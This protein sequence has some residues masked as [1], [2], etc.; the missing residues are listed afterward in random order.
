MGG[1]QPVP[2]VSFVSRSST[3]LYKLYILL[4][5]FFD[6]A[7]SILLKNNLSAILKKEPFFSEDY[8]LGISPPFNLPIDSR[9]TLAAHHYTHL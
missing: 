7:G 3:L 8:F 4:T 2:T 6:L 1:N 9:L 5:P